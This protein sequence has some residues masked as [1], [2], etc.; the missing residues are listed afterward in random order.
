MTEEP[1]MLQLAL[2]K[3]GKYHVGDMWIPEAQCKD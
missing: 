3:K 2:P 1:G